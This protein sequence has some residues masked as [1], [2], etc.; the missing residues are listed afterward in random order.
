MSV[1]SVIGATP[2]FGNYLANVEFV[3]DYFTFRMDVVVK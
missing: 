2:T 1:K 3:L